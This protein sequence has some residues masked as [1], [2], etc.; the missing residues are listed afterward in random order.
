M[1]R[2]FFLIS[3]LLVVENLFSQSDSSARKRI[4]I[5]HSF[6][7]RE[8]KSRKNKKEL[9]EKLTDSLKSLLAIRIQK[10]DLGEPVIIP[11]LIPAIFDS[12]TSLDSLF[13]LYQA[14]DAIVIKQL[15]AYFE[16][17][18]VEVTRN[19]DGSKNREAY[20]DLCTEVSYVLYKV[21]VDPYHS[22]TK[23]CDPFTTRNVISGMFASG[24]DIVGK[25]KHVFK[26]MDENAKSYIRE[27]DSRIK[28]I[29]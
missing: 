15:D 4:L 2:I 1:R 24:P 5:L 10:E 27:I 22:K 7:A 28:T 6:N 13:S 12:K 9:F 25:S 23:L 16:Q 19:N 17:R 14:T 18:R 29:H 20:Y 26:A 3:F 8:V 11:E 21:G